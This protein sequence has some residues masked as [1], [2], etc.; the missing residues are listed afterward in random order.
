MNVELMWNK[1][2]CKNVKKYVQEMLNV[3]RNR[4]QI[5]SNIL[6]VL[7]RDKDLAA[8]FCTIGGALYHERL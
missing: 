5:L 1:Q 8:I 3:N 6:F 2:I 4:K 7:L